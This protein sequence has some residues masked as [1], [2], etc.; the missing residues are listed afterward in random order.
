MGSRL[1]PVK[2]SPEVLNFSG[3]LVSPR[4]E[5]PR[6]PG[7]KIASWAGKSGVTES[8]SHLSAKVAVED[9]ITQL[10]LLRRTA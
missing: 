3:T 6:F 10:G 9:E 4:P 5:I 2:S 8:L 1:V 7:P